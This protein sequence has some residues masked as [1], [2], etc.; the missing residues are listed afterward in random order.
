MN[1]LKQTNSSD[2]PEKLGPSES[3]FPMSRPLKP[4]YKM[5]ASEEWPKVAL[6]DTEHFTEVLSSIFFK[7]LKCS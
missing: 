6:P 2:A 5:L 4:Q 3:P 7:K 1:S